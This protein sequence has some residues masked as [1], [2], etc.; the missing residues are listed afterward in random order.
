MSENMPKIEKGYIP[1][2]DTLKAL[3]LWL[4]VLGHANLTD[5]TLK[6]AIFSFHMPL[7]FVISGYLFKYRGI[8]EQVVKS[9]KT[10]LVPYFIVNALCL[11]LNLISAFKHGELTLSFLWDNAFPIFVGLGYNSG[12][13]TPVC[14]P[15]WFFYVM[16]FLQILINIVG[17]N[18]L[19]CVI[20]VTAS[21]LSCWVM[22]M[23]NINTTIPFDSLLMAIPF[24]YLGMG[25]KSFI[26]GFALK[27][28]V[29]SY[30]AT[31]VLMIIGLIV[32]MYNGRVDMNSFNF[33]S[34]ILLFYTSASAT[35]CA[36]LYISLHIGG[37]KLAKTIAVG[38]PIIVG[39]NLTTT[40][41]IKI[42]VAILFPNLTWNNYIGII[43]SLVSLCI[44]LMVSMVAQ[45]YLPA[46][47]GY[48]K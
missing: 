13:Y 47:L 37:G 8:K 45:R 3:G 25:I 36:L 1:G 26:K 32:G 38:A 46:I 39:F 9:W 4:M 48:R 31:L 11:I 6:I 24:F 22:K 15:M 40:P 14:P 23:N 28:G 7:F 42:F 29:L 10:I 17:R 27:M 12:E 20:L 19:H 16:F 18:I 34:S 2:I 21:L 43:V 33:G 30:G 35:C 44:L 41:I 5:G